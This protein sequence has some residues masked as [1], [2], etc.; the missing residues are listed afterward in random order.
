LAALQNIAAASQQ[1][2]MPQGAILGQQAPLGTQ[3]VYSLSTTNPSL[4]PH[5]YTGQQLS[6]VAQVQPPIP[7]AVQ[8]PQV[9]NAQQRDISAT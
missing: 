5:Q 4:A 9:C 1:V 8:F 3:T 6:M 2:G 7:P